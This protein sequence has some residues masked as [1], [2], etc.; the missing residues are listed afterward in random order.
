MSMRIIALACVLWSCAIAA[1]DPSDPCDP[2][3]FEDHGYCYLLD[4]G[5]D[6][7]DAALDEDG[8]ADSNPNATFGSPCVKQSD[9]GGIAPICGGPMLPLCTQI[10]CLD[11]TLCPAGWQCFDITKYAQEIA[12][13]VTSACIPTQ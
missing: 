11:T 8:G 4:G 3:Y 10:Q 7:R 12:P 9:C 6:W 5:F 1:C 13:G 2:G